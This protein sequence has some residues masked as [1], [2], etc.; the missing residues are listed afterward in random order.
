MIVADREEIVNRTRRGK[1]GKQIEAG[2]APGTLVPLAVPAQP[3][4][5]VERMA[6]TQRLPEMR[7]T[8]QQSTKRKTQ[9]RLAIRQAPTHDAKHAPQG[10]V[11]P[12]QRELIQL[13]YS[14]EPA[15]SESPTAQPVVTQNAFARKVLDWNRLASQCLNDNMYQETA[16][17]LK[18]ANF[19]TLEDS[20]FEFPS[21]TERKRLR[22]TTLNNIGCLHKR[23]SNHEKALDYLNVVRSTEMELNDASPSTLLNL[24]ALHT[25]LK[26]PDAALACCTQ[27][28][29]LLRDKM[30]KSMVCLESI[31]PWGVIFY[32][33]RLK[34]I[35]YWGT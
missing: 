9:T 6:L 4:E 28:I 11:S 19:A 10:S 14:T 33:A 27:A 16:R 23:L 29:V 17:Y 21:E 1:R 18:K 22:A 35:F 24:S 20:N 31:L 3:R 34:S 13:F 2:T 25:T 7:T 12:E 32:E 8:S 15:E 26:R 30:A 5:A